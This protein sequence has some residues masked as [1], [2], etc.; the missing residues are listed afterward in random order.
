MPRTIAPEICAGP[1]RDGLGLDD[2][3]AAWVTP[4][5][6]RSFWITT[7]SRPEPRQDAAGD[8]RRGR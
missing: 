6:A 2:R 4:G 7:V 5:R 8:D 1:M 3:H